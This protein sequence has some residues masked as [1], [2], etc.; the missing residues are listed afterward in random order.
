M[1][2]GGTERD[3]AV[4][5]DIQRHLKRATTDGVE[6]VGQGL[7]CHPAGRIDGNSDR[8]SSGDVGR[9]LALASDHAFDES[10]QKATGVQAH[11]DPSP[12]LLEDYP[13]RHLR[14]QADEGRH[15]GSRDRTRP[16]FCIYDDDVTIVVGID[17]DD[18]RRRNTGWRRRRNDGLRWRRNN[19]RRRRND[20]GNGPAD[21]DRTGPG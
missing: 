5:D 15:V 3:D 11:V 10:Q 1:E 4:R 2:T 6:N 20:A 14:R 9:D 16:Q 18:R 12:D 13:G 8:D 19:G 7:N 21:R 17:D